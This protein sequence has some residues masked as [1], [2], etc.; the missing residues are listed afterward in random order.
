MR[1]VYVM[2]TWSGGITP[3][4]QGVLFMG[5]ALGES[6]SRVDVGCCSPSSR[7]QDI[8]FKLGESRPR[9]LFLGP[10]SCF[11]EIGRF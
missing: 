9:T 6:D 8:C 3:A 1:V 10:V 7:T 5:R 11:M 2:D 4:C